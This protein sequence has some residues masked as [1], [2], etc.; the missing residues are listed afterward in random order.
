MAAQMNYNYGTPKGVPGGKVDISFDEVITRTNEADDGALKFGI[1]AAIGSKP[2]LNVTV[3][4]A[5]TTANQIEGIVLCHPNTEQNANGKVVVKKNVSVGIVKKGH[6]WGRIASG[7]TPA[8]GG[9]AYVSVT[10]VD[11]GTFTNVSEGALDIGAVFGNEVDD[12][13]AVVILK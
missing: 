9:K 11:A 1:A 12:G 2:G 10:G 5:G 6:V 7:I 4:I 8:Y 3:P 13:I